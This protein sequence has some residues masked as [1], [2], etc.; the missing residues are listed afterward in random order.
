M[1]QNIG[2][3]ERVIS[4][5]AGAGLVALA[6]KKSGTKGKIVSGV[7]GGLLGAR[8]AT[9][10]CP[11]KAAATEV[12]DS[13][14]GH[15]IR[16]E[17][18]AV[19]NAPVEQVYAFWNN[20]ENFPKFMTTLDSVVKMT[21]ERS[22]WVSKAPFGT[23][24]EWDAE[25]TKNVPNDV[26]AWESVAGD[27]ENRGE[28]RFKRVG[29]KTRIKVRI[30][31]TPPGGKVGETVAWLFGEDP[32]SQLEKYIKQ[33]KTLLEGHDRSIEQIKQGSFGETRTASA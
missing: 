25:T 30:E 6:L 4:A 13:F 26:I 8:A 28:V 32:K 11:A 1:K 2:T 5:L 7:T 27:V 3:T 31:Y 33:V 14:T 15:P 16:V 17:K 10:F 18:R 24:V 23:K 20:V 21:E 22:H 9:G 29:H 12:S 19:I